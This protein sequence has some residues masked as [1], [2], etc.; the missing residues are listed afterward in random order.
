MAKDDFKKAAA[1]EAEAK[2]ALD[3]ARADLAKCLNRPRMR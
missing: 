2:E 3:K 1:A